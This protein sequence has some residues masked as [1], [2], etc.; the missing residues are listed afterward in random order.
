[1]TNTKLL[2]SKIETSGYDLRFI[3]S[4]VGMS[5]QCFLKKMN[6][7]SEFRASE[8]MALSDLLG[9]D[10]EELEAVFFCTSYR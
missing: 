4:K 8:I 5:Y 6:N 9:L 10:T 3:A 7:Q 2:Q 1:M